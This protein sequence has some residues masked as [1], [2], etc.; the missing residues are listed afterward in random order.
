MGGDL[1]KLAISAAF[2]A[3]ALVAAAPVVAA[4]FRPERLVVPS[5]VHQVIVGGEAEDDPVIKRTVVHLLR[6]TSKGTGNCTA[7]AIAPRVLLTA[8][9][10]FI[11]KSSD[12]KIKA[13]KRTIK[14]TGYIAHPGFK[15][16]RPTTLNGV[17]I[18]A[19]TENDIAIV[20]LARD[21]AGDDE[22]FG[23]LSN[24]TP[25]SVDFLVGI[26]VMLSGYG[27][28]KPDDRST[29]G[30][31]RSVEARME[32]WGDT[33]S[34][35]FGSFNTCQGDSGGPAYATRNGKHIIV[36]VSST[37]N[38]EDRGA[39]TRVSDYADWI[40]QKVRAQG[41]AIEEPVQVIDGGFGRAENPAVDSASLP[42]SEPDAERND[43]PP[44][45]GKADPVQP[46]PPGFPKP[47]LYASKD[48][49]IAE[50]GSQRQSE[51]GP[52]CA[53]RV[54]CQLQ[55]EASMARWNEACDNLY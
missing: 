12:Q 36:G 2:T 32:E 54:G 24:K 3:A 35:A 43:T 44:P 42:T 45:T 4:S 39:Y 31:L 23:L 22:T 20:F 55:M 7:A 40:V 27:M 37:A 25:I 10:C 9:H 53:L 47:G 26:E 1:R 52:A 50:G 38:C 48:D 17:R 41:Y 30:S 33:N 16:E 14:V 13:G 8:A 46:E 28:T 6:K 18:G 49:C 11:N 51:Y 15:Y 19:K 34:L 29:L 5:I 21:L